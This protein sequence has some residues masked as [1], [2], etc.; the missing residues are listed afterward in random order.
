M[1]LNHKVTLIE[2]SNRTNKHQENWKLINKINRR[3][4]TKKSILKGR[5]KKE[6][7]KNWYDYF[8]KLLS[9]P[10]MI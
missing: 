10:P 2:Q 6:R 7:V 9:K 3:K 1:E 5:N 8:K 4:T